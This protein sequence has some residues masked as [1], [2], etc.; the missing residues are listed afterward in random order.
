M[1]PAESGTN[2]ERT[3]TAGRAERENLSEKDREK[4]GRSKRSG[5]TSDA[6]ERTEGIIRRTAM[7]MIL[8][9]KAEA[10]RDPLPPDCR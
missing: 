5:P 4:N 8:D 7:S 6:V 3:E 2:H 10:E 9:E 1:E